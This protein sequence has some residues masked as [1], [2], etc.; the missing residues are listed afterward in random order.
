LLLTAIVAVKS[1]HPLGAGFIAAFP[2]PLRATADPAELSA[3]RIND[4]FS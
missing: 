1:N 4:S 3:E 2:A